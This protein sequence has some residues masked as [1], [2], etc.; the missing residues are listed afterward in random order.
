MTRSTTPSSG[1]PLLVGRSRERSLL[2]AQLSA[3]LAGQGGLVILSGEAGIGKTT[4]AEDACREASA[5]GALVLVGHCYDRTETPPY[6]PWVE[7]LE[8]F[9]TLPD[10]SPALHAI[11]EPDL[12]RSAS[13]V[14]LFAQVRGLPRR[15]RARTAARDPPG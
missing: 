9:G 12:T 1:P 11:A 5:A 4:L 10:R 8:Q 14:A 3:A 2:R 13:Q 15:P 7:L 6:G